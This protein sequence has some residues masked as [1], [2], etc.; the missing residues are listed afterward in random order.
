MEIRIDA[1]ELL[2]FA[3]A[4]AQAPGALRAEMTNANAVLLHE[5]IGYAQE[6][7]PRD[8][9]NLAGSIRVLDGPNAEGGAYGSDLVYA[10]QREEGG[11]IYPRNGKFLV[12]EVDGE[13]VFA[14]SVTQTGSHYMQ[15]SKDRLEPRVEPVYQL[16]V[17]R[18][19]GR[20]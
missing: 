9:G 11:T 7:V 6:E 20:V 15:K 16:A 1:S 18:V 14:R 10:W 4:M 5:G 19:L 2:G 8:S 12:F 3:E 13:L 17:D